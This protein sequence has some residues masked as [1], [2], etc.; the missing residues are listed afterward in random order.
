MAL[1][2]EL[3]DVDRANDE[4]LFAFPV[5]RMLLDAADSYLVDTLSVSANRMSEAIERRD[6]LMI[7]GIAL[8]MLP[9][10]L[11]EV[12]PQGGGRHSGHRSTRK[13]RRPTI[14][15][16]TAT[17]KET[18]V[19]K[20]EGRSSISWVLPADCVPGADYNL[21]EEA[22]S[23]LCTGLQIMGIRLTHTVN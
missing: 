4:V 23:T 15:S 16:S 14:T 13:R 3:L 1:G 10:H 9:R 7:I 17:A 20:S 22:Q 18:V 6:D 5:S 2:F 11:R 21:A 8:A 12:S 19:S